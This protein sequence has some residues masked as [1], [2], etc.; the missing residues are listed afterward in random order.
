MEYEDGLLWLYHGHLES[1]GD[2]EDAT[3]YEYDDTLQEVWEA[4]EAAADR[5][6]GEL[7][8]EAQR[9]S[10]WG[11]H[12]HYLADIAHTL[13]GDGIGVWDGRWDEQIL[14]GAERV[15]EG[16]KRKLAKWI[17]G[18]GSGALCEAFDE[19]LSRHLCA[20]IMV[21][22]AHDACM[23]DV[24]EGKTWHEEGEAH[25][26]LAINEDGTGPSEGPLAWC[27]SA[28]IHVDGERDTVTVSVSVGDPRGAF[29]ME[30]RR[31]PDGTILLHLPHPGESLPHCETVELHPGTLAVK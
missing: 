30:V 11:A 27:N 25:I 21:C 10:I 23:T 5:A 2:V 3:E 29:T 7:V 15:S 14:G 17:D 18:S 16:L 12:E 28:A 20:P 6:L 8:T 19:C 24:S 4:F 31:K 13:L 26:H 1:R 22:T 9:D